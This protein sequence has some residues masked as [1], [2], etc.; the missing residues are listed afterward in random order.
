MIPWFKPKFW[1]NEKKYAMDALDS[2]WISDGEYIRK[3]E[4]NFKESIG[5]KN[6]LTVSNRTTALYLALLA[7]DIGLGDE[8]IIPGYTFAAPANMV[9]AVGAK[10]VF[11]D[12]NPDTWLIETTKIEAVITPRTKAIIPVHIY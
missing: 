11:V 8:V 12:V 2:T 3:F 5:S 4:K 7:H 1:G 10:P 6:F 9:L